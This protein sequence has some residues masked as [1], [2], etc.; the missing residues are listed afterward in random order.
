MPL[1]EK[2]VYCDKLCIYGKKHFIENIINKMLSHFTL[3]ELKFDS[4][5]LQVNASL[6]DS[7]GNRI[8]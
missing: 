2:N 3:T 8:T 6:E 4:I 1:K 5:K 7:V